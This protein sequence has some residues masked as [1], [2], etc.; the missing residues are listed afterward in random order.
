MKRFSRNIG[1]RGHMRLN[2]RGM[3][4]IDYVSFIEE[5]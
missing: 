4:Y 1:V 3:T 2:Y 5:M